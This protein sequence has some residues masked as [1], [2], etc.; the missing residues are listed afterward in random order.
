MGA[1]NETD[2]KKKKRSS[3]KHIKYIE[4]SKKKFRNTEKIGV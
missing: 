4:E 1:G 3:M 2:I